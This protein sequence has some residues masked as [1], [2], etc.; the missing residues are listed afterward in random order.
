MSDERVTRVLLVDDHNLVRAGVRRII[1]SQTGFEVVG[2]VGDGSR[3]FGPSRRCR[4]TWWCS[5]SPCQPWTA[6]RC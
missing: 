3:R 4:S 5:I 2:E 6:S 1:E